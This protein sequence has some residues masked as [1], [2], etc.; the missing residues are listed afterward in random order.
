MQGAGPHNGVPRF[1]MLTRFQEEII[2]PDGSFRAFSGMAPRMILLGAMSAALALGPAPIRAVDAI[3]QGRPRITGLSHVAL[4]VGDLERSRAF[5]KGYL[6]FD[7]PYTLNNR[8]GGVLLTWIKVNDRQSIELFPISDNTPKNGDSLYHI[9]LET[10]DAQ[11]MLDY[12]TSK[13]VMAPGGK[14]LPTTARAGQIGNLN[15]FTEDPDGHIVEF[16]QYMPNG[17]TVQKSGQFMPPTRIASRMS[18][19]GI[20]VGNLEAS[21]HFYR[22]IL[23]FREFWRGSSDG[24][25]L[26]W[27]NLRTPEGRDYIE[28]MLYGTR[29]SLA[30]LHVL[31]HLCL[32]VN[33]ASSAG[34]TLKSRPLPDG[35]PAP[36]PVR[37][38][39][40]GKRQINCY[41]PDGTRVEMMEANTADGKPATPSDAP[42]PASHAPGY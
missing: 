6:G 28:L 40:N 38:G 11:G 36:T 2:C 10:D 8:A 15:Y 42:P 5:Y 25:T 1:C 33:D 14:P 21:L 23:G 31:N 3:P 19:A 24:K 20:I 7:E 39:R 30:Q 27:V 16:T 35:C 9:A 22:D 18:H 37:I 29:P 32:E 26:S 17:W 12:L 13:G 34:D 41:D 4:W